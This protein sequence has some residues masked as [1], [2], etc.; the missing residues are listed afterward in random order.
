MV[1]ICGGADNIHPSL[2]RG[3]VKYKAQ[4]GRICYTSTKTMNLNAASD[5]L[6]DKK[7]I[8][9][10]KLNLTLKYDWE[11]NRFEENIENFNENG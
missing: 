3:T 4:R 11:F 7:P 5:P 6:T 1:L 9:I 8:P 10:P 2:V